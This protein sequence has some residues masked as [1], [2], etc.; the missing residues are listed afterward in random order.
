MDDVII[1]AKNLSKYMHDIEMH[2]K[3]RD[4][5]DYTNYYLGNEMIQVGDHIHVS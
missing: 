3:A 5:T 1:A 4:I 2:F